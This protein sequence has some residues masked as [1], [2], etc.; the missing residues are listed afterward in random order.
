MPSCGEA[1]LSGARK[2]QRQTMA[3]RASMVMIMG[4][5]APHRAVGGPERLIRRLT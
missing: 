3:L 4:Q 5:D 1:G 2:R